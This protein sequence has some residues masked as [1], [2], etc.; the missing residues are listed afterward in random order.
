[1]TIFLMHGFS[2]NLLNIRSSIR[3]TEKA[4]EDCRDSVPE[5]EECGVGFACGGLPV[6]LEPEDAS[7]A[8][9]Q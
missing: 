1:M 3:N 7:L 4:Y 9:S 6:L 2:H 8:K 5:D